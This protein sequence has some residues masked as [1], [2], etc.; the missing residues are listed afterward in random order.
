[1]HEF[2]SGE[3]K[4]REVILLTGNLDFIELEIPRNYIIEWEEHLY[5][6]QK[7]IFI[8]L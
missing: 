7:T 6:N 1:M 4:N 3:R 8:N 2:G 5:A